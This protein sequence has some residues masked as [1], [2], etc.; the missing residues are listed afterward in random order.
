MDI[1][2]NIKI[3]DFGLANIINNMEETKED[4]DYNEGTIHF[5]APEFFLQDKKNKN[6]K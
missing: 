5:M 2:G 1:L 3:A 4:I 6:E